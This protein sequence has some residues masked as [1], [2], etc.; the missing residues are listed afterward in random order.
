MLQ[1]GR[2]FFFEVALLTCDPGMVVRPLSSDRG[3]HFG[4][5]SSL[6]V[7]CKYDDEGRA[8]WVCG[9]SEVAIGC[10]P[11]C[12]RDE[13]CTG[14]CQTACRKNRQRGTQSTT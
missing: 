8:R 6:R 9:K 5:V 14:H 10:G 4:G 3:A 2:G 11:Q 7:V 1:I 13:E 12:K